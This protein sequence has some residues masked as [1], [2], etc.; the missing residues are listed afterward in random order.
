MF[1]DVFGFPVPTAEMCPGSK[2]LRLCGLAGVVACHVLFEGSASTCFKREEG[3]RYELPA[4]V[5]GTV[6]VLVR[7]VAVAVVA[8]AGLAVAVPALVAT[9]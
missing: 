5:P 7:G 3:S 8:A 6:Q 1:R 2:R 4:P 9:R